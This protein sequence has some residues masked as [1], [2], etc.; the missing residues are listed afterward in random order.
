MSV[1][2]NILAPDERTALNVAASVGLERREWQTFTRPDH[3]RGLTELTAHQLAELLARS[4]A[5]SAANA[6]TNTTR[7]T[8]RNVTTNV[9]S[10][11]TTNVTRNDT[12]NVTG[13]AADHT[14]LH[15]GMTPDCA[16]ANDR[17]HVSAIA[18]RCKLLLDPT[19]HAVVDHRAAEGLRKDGQTIDDN[20]KPRRAKAVHLM[21]ELLDAMQ[22]VAWGAVPGAAGDALAVMANDLLEATPGLTFEAL[23]FKEGHSGS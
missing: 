13:H 21:Q 19:L 9:T 4:A 10:D 17:R 20:A 22:Y 11:A 3:L 2:V 18:E 16:A 15:A 8:T 5:K 7:N 23:T 12:A 14:T 1:L 6:T